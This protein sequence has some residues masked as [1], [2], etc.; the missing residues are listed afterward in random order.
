M[1]PVKLLGFFCGFFL[2]G[3]GGQV[4]VKLCYK[5][6]KGY[7][8]SEVCMVI[9]KMYRILMFSLCFCCVSLQMCCVCCFV[10]ASFGGGGGGVF[11]IIILYQCITQRFFYFQSCSWQT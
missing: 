5:K 8:Y 4:H 11:F 7:L 1:M 3:W 9:N 2:G 6:N 10:C